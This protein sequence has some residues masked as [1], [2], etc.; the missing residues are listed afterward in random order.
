MTPLTHFHKYVRHVNYGD[1]DVWCISNSI[2]DWF[3]QVTITEAYLALGMTYTDEAKTGNIVPYRSLDEINF[4]K[5]SFRFDTVQQR[6]RAP[7]ALETIREMPMWI[8]GKVDTYELTASNLEQ[9]VRELAQHPKEVFDRELPPF[10]V[11]RKVVSKK[12]PVYFLT[13]EAY[14]LDEFNKLI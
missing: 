11:A 2:I 13:Y 12:Y 1:D 4:L 8:H 14:Q 3:N 9:A 6:W 7:L 5:R 10:E